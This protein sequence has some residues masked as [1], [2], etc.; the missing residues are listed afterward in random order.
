[1]GRIETIASNGKKELPHH[2]G[3]ARDELFLTPQGLVV[4]GQNLWIESV[5]GQSLWR[6][7]LKRG[8]IH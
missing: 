7:H 2:R 3:M 6:S 4:R 5:S 1:M 8:T